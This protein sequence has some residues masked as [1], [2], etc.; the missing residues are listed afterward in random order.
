MLKAWALFSALPQI[1]HL[2]EVKLHL[3][4]CLQDVAEANSGYLRIC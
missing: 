2:L 1:W 4:E 3:T